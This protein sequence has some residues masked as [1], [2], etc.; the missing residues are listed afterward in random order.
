MRS[1]RKDGRNPSDPSTLLYR[2]LS[3]EKID[4]ILPGFGLV[5]RDFKQ[6]IHFGGLA[7]QTLGH[8]PEAYHNDCW[9]DLLHPDDQDRIRMVMGMVK[10]GERDIVAEEFRLQDPDGKWHWIRHT[11]TVLARTPKGIPELYAGIEQDISD[12]RLQAET[13]EQRYIEAETLRVAGAILSTELDPRKAAEQVLEQARTVIPFDTAYIWLLNGN[14]LNYAGGRHPLKGIPETIPANDPDYLNVIEARHP[15]YETL[16]AD[17][18]ENSVFAARLAVPL[19]I[20]NEVIG[21]M[22]FFAR[23]DGLL[24]SRHIWP[25]IAFGDYVAVVIRNAQSHHEANTEANIDWMTDIYTRRFF[26]RNAIMKLTSVY[27]NKPS[28]LLLVDLDH[29]KSINDRFGHETGDVALRRTA[30][31]LKACIRDSDLAGR[32]GGD[33]FAIFLPGAITKVA[34]GIA[35]QIRAGIEAIKFPEWPDLVMTASIGLYTSSKSR[36]LYS[37]M[38]RRADAA[39]YRS[40]ESGRNQIQSSE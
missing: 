38:L 40:K 10:K 36:D 6:N 32:L 25:G 11:A 4:H 17:A 2:F 21:C 16:N 35:Q 31:V 5:L 30:D 34:T 12:L 33:E 9:Q 13:F 27:G 18:E 26:E 28:S 37:E 8:K 19:V 20:K 1:T 29:F 39:M 22:E 15:V 7:V 14:T 3:H 23:T 24:E